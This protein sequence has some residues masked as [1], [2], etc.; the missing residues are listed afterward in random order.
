MLCVV[1]R[2]YSTK[3]IGENLIDSKEGRRLM[4]PDNNFWRDA[5]AG[6]YI[7]H[8]FSLTQ[9]QVKTFNGVYMG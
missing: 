4:K 5:M 7:G 6:V 9:N 8:R 2:V 1:K 3:V